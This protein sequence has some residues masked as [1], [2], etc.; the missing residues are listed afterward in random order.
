MIQIGVGIT[1]RGAA[2]VLPRVH[3]KIIRECNRRT[4]AYRVEKL[5]PQHFAPDAA[6]KYHYEQRQSTINLGWLFR[7]NRALWEKVPKLKGRGGKV[8]NRAHYRDVKSILGLEPLVWT[9]S[10]RKAVLNPTNVTN[11]RATPSRAT[12]VIKKTGY[13]TSSLRPR[14]GLVKYAQK[15]AQALQRSSEVEAITPGE[16][17]HLRAYFA[18]QYREILR[19]PMD[20]AHSFLSQ[21]QAAGRVLRSRQR[22]S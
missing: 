3:K 14:E 12:L 18:Q 15:Q 8:L 11:I 7:T 10:L 1:T 17:R 13:A 9:G 5:L 16:R 21:E 4:M 6:E 2:K 20:P 19:N 22:R